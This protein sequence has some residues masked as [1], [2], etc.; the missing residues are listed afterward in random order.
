MP[1]PPNSKDERELLRPMD[2]NVSRVKEW[3]RGEG[4]AQPVQRPR[5]GKAHGRSEVVKSQLQ[6]CSTEDEP[7]R[8]LEAEEV[9][10]RTS[11]G[12]TLE[13]GP[14]GTG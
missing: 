6:L 13:L 2:N 9:C 11:A 14:R 5:G 1:S 7:R 10:G 4:E 12:A 3:G 8:R